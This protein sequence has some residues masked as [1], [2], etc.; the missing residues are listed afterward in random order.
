MYCFNSEWIESNLRYIIINNYLKGSIQKKIC[1]LQKLYL[2]S[3]HDLFV[4][5]KYV[6]YYIDRYIWYFNKNFLRDLFIYS[7]DFT[8][9]YLSSISP[10]N[11]LSIPYK[12]KNTF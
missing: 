12:H 9:F 8:D 7:K 5:C 2:S 1:L 10:Y 4:H 3:L 6:K 11:Y